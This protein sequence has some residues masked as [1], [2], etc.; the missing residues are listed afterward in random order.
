V[1]GPTG[2]PQRGKERYRPRRRDNRA[3]DFKWPRRTVV[4]IENMARDAFT[5]IDDIHNDTT[6]ER[7]QAAMDGLN[8]EGDDQWNEV[9]LEHLVQESTQR[10]FEGSSQNRLQCC[11]VLFS[12]CSLYSVPHTFLDALLT[13]IAGDLLSTSNCFPRTS[14]EVKTMLMRLALK[15][16]QIH[17]C[18]DGHILYE[19]EYE[20]LE[21]CHVCDLPRFIDGSNR[22]PQRVVRYFDVI[23]HLLQMFKMP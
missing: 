17:C 10:V 22:V 6:N 7:N 15:N 23:K 18:P 11:I 4:D 5:R 1:R 20:D 8:V 2:C 12:M 14:Y 13:W 21:K 19:G 3:D 16:K 9:N